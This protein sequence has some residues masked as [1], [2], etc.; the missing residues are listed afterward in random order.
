MALTAKQRQFVSEYLV[1]LNATQ[2][3][4]RAGY[5]RKN[6]MRIGYQ[7]LQRNDVQEAVQEAMQERAQRVEI[8]QD[9]VVDELAK[10][11]FAQ[12]EDGND[13]KLRVGN[14]LKALELLGKHLGMFDGK[15]GEG[16]AQREDDPITKSLKEA[17][18]HGLF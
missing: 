9:R 10:V 12:A 1:D 7:L 16:A 4:A 18:E 14:K 6:A 13:S 3:A 11:G 2:A 17:A 8:T 5:S 15:S